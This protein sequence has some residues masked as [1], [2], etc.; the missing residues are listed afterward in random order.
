MARPRIVP[1]KSEECGGA[2]AATAGGL[3]RSCGRVLYVCKI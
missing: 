2:F 1:F 3:C